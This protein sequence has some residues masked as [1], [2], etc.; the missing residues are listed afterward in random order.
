MPVREAAVLC[1]LTGLGGTGLFETGT[2]L[3]SV[4]NGL[5]ETG[6]LCGPGCSGNGLPEDGAGG[7]LLSSTIF[8]ASSK[9]LILS[10]SI[11]IKLLVP[12]VYTAAFH[13]HCRFKNGSRR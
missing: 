9:L 11:D 13:S 4:F 5:E 2:F 6:S 7:R 1:V 10:R 3:L 12:S 8:K